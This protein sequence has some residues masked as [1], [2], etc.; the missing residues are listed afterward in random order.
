MKQENLNLITKPLHREEYYNP[1]W[2]RN[3][4]R[5]IVD[6]RHED[7]LI[8]ESGRVT[9]PFIHLLS[10][11]PLMAR[12]GIGIGIIVIC[13][14]GPNIFSGICFIIAMLSTARAIYYVRPFRKYARQVIRAES[15]LRILL[16]KKIAECYLKKT[17]LRL[18]ALQNSGKHRSLER[19]LKALDK[20]IEQ[21][22]QEGKKLEQEYH[23]TMPKLLKQI[24]I[25]GNKGF[26]YSI[27]P[28]RYNPAANVG[29]EWME[30]P[31]AIAPIVKII[32]A[33][34]K[35]LLQQIE[36]LKKEKPYVK[37]V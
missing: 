23:Q 22:R 6:E 16:P 33:E 35:R 31:K 24:R 21:H 34:E 14:L 15:F 25:L 36:T 37:I 29:F 20:K 7:I 26:T 19:K 1:Y 8:K 18:E 5:E 30:D 11:F 27:D 10:F 32:M 9:A 4:C 28:T 13:F 17:E 3:E 12:A 2:F